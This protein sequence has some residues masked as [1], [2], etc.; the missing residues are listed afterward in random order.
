M[1][2]RA[3]RGPGREREPVWGADDHGPFL[4]SVLASVTTTR[5]TQPKPHAHPPSYKQHTLTQ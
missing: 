1:R 4:A 5:Q 2:W 3:G